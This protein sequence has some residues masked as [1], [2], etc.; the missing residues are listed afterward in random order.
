MIIVAL[1]GLRSRA[2]GLSLQGGVTGDAALC[3]RQPTR[4]LVVSDK[5]ADVARLARQDPAA[6]RCK[7][8]RISHTIAVVS[9]GYSQHVN[10]RHHS[11]ATSRQHVVCRQGLL[12]SHRAAA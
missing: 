10:A 1:S 6:A 4:S 7:I 8:G 9:S 11:S 12:C 5:D 3:S 2:K